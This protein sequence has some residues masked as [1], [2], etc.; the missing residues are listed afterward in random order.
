MSVNIGDC[1]AVIM[2]NIHRSKGNV[3]PNF[4]KRLI[5]APELIIICIRAI[6]YWNLSHI[7]C[8]VA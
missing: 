8:S 1:E 5:P 4:I 2:L 7:H 3:V 6:L